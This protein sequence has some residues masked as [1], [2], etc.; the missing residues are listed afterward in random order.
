MMSILARVASTALIALLLL[1]PGAAA[2]QGEPWMGKLDSAARMLLMAQDRA[3][4]AEPRPVYF[5][6]LDVSVGPG[7]ALSA[8]FFVRVSDPG[9]VAALEAAGFHLQTLAGDVAVGRAP[10]SVLGRIAALELVESIS[11][12]QFVEPL[13]D[14][15]N[16][17]IN[18]FPVHFGINLP[19]AY[20]GEGVVVGV[21]DTGI[22]VA[23]PDFLDENGSRIEFLLEYQPGGGEQQ[24]TR[25][26][27]NNSL[28]NHPQRDINGHGT[29]VAGT[30]AG[31]GQADE[32][33]TFTGVAPASRL[34]I[35]KGTRTGS[36][37][38]QGLSHT[39]SQADIVNG[40]AWIFDRAAQ[41]GMPAVVNLSLGSPGGSLDGTEN[42]IRAL[43]N[44]A[45]PGR[46]LVFAGGNNGHHVLHAGT[47]YGAG[48]SPTMV[49][50]Y[51]PTHG[52]EHPDYGQFI[53][54]QG[55]Y[56]SGTLSTI[57]I[58]ARHRDTYAVVATTSVPVG[59]SLE[60]IIPLR[61]GGETIGYIYLEA[62]VTEH[63]NTNAGLFNAYV[64][65]RVS[66]EEENEIDLRDYVWSVTTPSSAPGR[67]DAWLVR[68]DMGS[69][70]Q[71]ASGI[72]NFVPGDTRMTLN[73]YAAGERILS[74]GAHTTRTSWQ[75]ASGE[76][77][78]VGY[79][80]SARAPF[81]SEGPTR[82]GRIRPDVAAPGAYVGS[83]L[84]RHS[85]NSLSIFGHP[86]YTM[87]QGTSMAAPFLAGA[88]ALM[89]QVD[90]TL[91]PERTRTFLQQTARADSHT[92]ALPNNRYGYGK[93]NVLAAVQAVVGSVSD[94]EGPMALGG[95]ALEAP[96]PNP[97]RSSVQLVYN[98]PRAAHASVTVYDVLGREVV[99]VT[100][101]E[102]TAGPHEA[103]LDTRGL[104]AG[105]YLVV[106]DADG[107]RHSRAFVVV[108]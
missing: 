2:Q 8:A 60:G 104:A 29:H 38:A 35:V 39:F 5:D 21:L 53:Q 106:L 68:S 100:E 46:I 93:L 31:T 6:Q 90:P 3:R 92:G 89:L 54:V 9:Q 78:T 23:H 43:S 19:R 72:P 18:T 77:V 76:T 97:A 59:E 64:L 70:L 10:V 80:M 91:D 82:D 81:S 25:A 58:S 48:A 45:G 24:W 102:A 107:E 73:R 94:E 75:N 32:A 79:T 20:R 67:V 49:F 27:I 99:R 15:G 85:P 33:E 87:K 63:P 13:N 30:A 1:T 88:V 7:G 47:D 62:H 41:L 83:S 98:L 11:V 16:F 66:E 34:I 61:D 96:Y 26:Q 56:T 51:R 4:G 101:G 108:R 28:Q 52:Y 86:M 37:P 103:V 105:T 17:D 50:E 71:S 36:D 12:S 40:T 22:D 69:F 14:Q 42:A 95:L 57:S 84:S 74:A 65:Q 44:L 55:W